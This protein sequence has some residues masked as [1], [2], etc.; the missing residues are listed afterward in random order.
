MSKAKSALVFWTD[1]LFTFSLYGG[2][3]IG[4]GCAHTQ[5]YGIS[6][7]A[8]S[9]TYGGCVTIALSRIVWSGCPLRLLESSFRGH[10]HIPNKSWLFAALTKNYNQE[11]ARFTIYC[12]CILSLIV[13]TT[14]IY[15]GLLL[16]RQY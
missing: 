11:T 8:I 1:V 3:F 16:W 10:E 5:Q 4:A 12:W 6:D 14:A 15:L 9:Y 7:L 13:N 2:L